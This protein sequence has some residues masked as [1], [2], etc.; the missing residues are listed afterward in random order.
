MDYLVKLYQNPFIE[1]AALIKA[2]TIRKP[3]GPE[4]HMLLDWIETHFNEKWRSEA[5]TA[6]SRKNSLFIAIENNEI[7]GFSCF[8]GTAKGFF[9]PLGVKE[10]ARAKG[11]GRQLLHKTLIAMKDYG[12]GYAVIPTT[13]EDYYRKYLDLI[14]INGS[15]KSVYHDMISN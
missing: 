12:Y 8:D 11:V 14:E 9:G 1:S 15:E 4:K 2:V 6:Y 7:L 3:I 13:S 10:N 5:D